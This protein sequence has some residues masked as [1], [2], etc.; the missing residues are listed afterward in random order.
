MTPGSG[1]IS[2]TLILG[3]AVLGENL[4][5]AMAAVRPDQIVRTGCLIVE[6]VRLTCHA[7]AEDQDLERFIVCEHTCTVGRKVPALSGEDLAVVP[8]LCS[9]EF[10]RSTMTD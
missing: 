9:R 4:A 2:K 3:G 6:E 8:Y 10:V 5:R 1:L 7:S